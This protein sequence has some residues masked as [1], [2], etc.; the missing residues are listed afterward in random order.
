MITISFFTFI[1]LFILAG[2]G[3]LYT[4]ILLIDLSVLIQN[5]R[6]KKETIR[7]K[8]VKSLKDDRKDTDAIIPL[9][10]NK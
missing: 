8:F 1:M 4:T 5:T 7:E 3:L 10:G 9:G 2:F 6:Q